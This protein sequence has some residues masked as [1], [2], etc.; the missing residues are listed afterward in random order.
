MLFDFSLHGTASPASA[1]R[2]LQTR[3]RRQPLPETHAD[4]FRSYLPPSTRKVIFITGVTRSSRMKR[5]K[6]VDVVQ[7]DGSLLAFAAGQ[8]HAAK[9]VAR[10]VA[11]F[12][13]R[14][15]RFSFDRPLLHCPTVNGSRW[16]SGRKH[17]LRA[18]DCFRSLVASGHK[19]RFFDGGIRR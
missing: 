15:A 1:A 3:S 13:G 4:L 10:V 14:C 11:G 19:V 16:L 17:S 8:F 6:P 2:P 9:N 5:A 12:L 7:S 18:G